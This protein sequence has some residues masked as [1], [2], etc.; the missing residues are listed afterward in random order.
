[1]KDNRNTFINQC[2]KNGI[3]NPYELLIE[4]YKGGMSGSEIKELLLNKYGIIV[5]DKHI[6]DK[7]KA[8]M[9][10]RTYSERKLNAIKRGRMIYFKKPEHEKYKRLGLSQK[11][12]MLALKRD[13]FKC[14]LCGNSP[15]TG[16][17]LEIHHING[18]KNNIENL[19][20]LCFPC[21]RG[22]HYTN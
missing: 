19:Q 7:I 20:T 2:H 14:S 5:S 8:K 4:L 11:Q 16:A 3:E 17:T 10:L 12:R 13:N 18:E 6:T 22:M 21:H 15:K 9:P 1:M